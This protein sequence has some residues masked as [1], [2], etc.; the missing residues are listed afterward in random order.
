MVTSGRG[1]FGVDCPVSAS[2]GVNFV[3]D[4]VTTDRLQPS[5]AC[6][7]PGPTQLAE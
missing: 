1:S 2:T 5:H 3:P 7:P 4:P 6:P